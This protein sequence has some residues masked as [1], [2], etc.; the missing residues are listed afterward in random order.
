MTQ[1]NQVYVGLDSWGEL[2]EL[3][4]IPSATP[5][6]EFIYSDYSVR[7]FEGDAQVVFMRDGDWHYVHA[8][9]CSCHGLEDQWEPE[10]FDPILHIEALAQGR[11]LTSRIDPALDA[12]L[13]WAAVPQMTA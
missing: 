7:G 2:C 13:A 8:M 10:A 12:W 1:Q 5:E 6:P 4:R 3:F 9:H 11:S